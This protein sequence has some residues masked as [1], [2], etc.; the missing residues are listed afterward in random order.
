MNQQRRRRLGCGKA[1]HPRCSDSL[2]KLAPHHTLTRE[3]DPEVLEL[4]H[5]SKELFPTKSRKSTSFLLR[6]MASDL[7]VMILMPVA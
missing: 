2:A 6:V 5:F 7:A 4:L 1:Y 3:Q